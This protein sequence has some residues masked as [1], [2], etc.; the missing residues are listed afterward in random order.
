MQRR[1]HTASQLR[2]RWIAIVI[3]CLGHAGAVLIVLCGSR[4]H[5]GHPSVNAETVMTLFTLENP[6]V[7]PTQA[8]LTTGHRNRHAIREQ[9][10]RRNEP[11]AVP[12]ES[13]AQSETA[14]S[15]DWAAQIHRAAED[16]I[17]RTT[18]E[19]SRRGLDRHPKGM[20]LPRTRQS[21]HT[22]GDTEYSEGGVIFDWINDRC[23]YTNRDPTGLPP[24]NSLGVT[25][26]C[27]PR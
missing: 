25:R 27:K 11:P 16:Y 6:R 5:P 21:G 15:I 14:P 3:I 18:R 20:E 1:A 22:L 24:A 8:H 23:F 17:A 10:D 26:I 7:P 4:L 9:P 13:T 19:E 2:E 12:P